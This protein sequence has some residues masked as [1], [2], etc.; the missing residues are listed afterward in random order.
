MNLIKTELSSRWAGYLTSD[1]FSKEVKAKKK[2]RRDVAD[3]TYN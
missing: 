3:G 2:Y 1:R